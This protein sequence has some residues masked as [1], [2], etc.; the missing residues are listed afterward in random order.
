MEEKSI[1]IIGAGIA[2]LSTGC[3]GQMNGYHTQI[4][5]MRDLPGGLCTSW[6]R[7][8][9][10]IDGC[11]GWLM[12]SGPGYNYYQLWQELGALHGKRIINHE[13]F[14][15]IVDN[16][17][18]AL[19]IY[20][21][22]D[23][24]EGHLKEL[25]PEDA[26]EI[27]KLIQ[28]AKTCSTFNPP[29]KKAPELM[30]LADLIPFLFKNKQFLKINS[31]YRNITL[32]DYVKKFKSPFLRKMF[33]FLLVDLFSLIMMLG[34]LHKKSAG[35]P[36]GGSLEFSRGIEQRYLNLGGKIHYSSPVTEIIVENNRATGVKLLD[37]SIHHS[38]II[39]SAA[40]GHATI[41]DMLGGKYINKK[42]Q[43]YYNHFP[44]FPSKILLSSGVNRTFDDSPHWII[45][46]LDTPIVIG[47]QEY[48]SLGVEIYN[49]DHTLAPHGKTVLRMMFDTDYTYWYDLK[50]D[51][52]RY[53]ME[54]KKIAETV[55]SILDKCYPG[56][57]ALVE[58]I[59][60]AT[61]ITW[62]RYTGNWKGSYQG[63]Q[64]TEKTMPPFR[65]S[66]KLPG[67]ESFYMAGQ[68]VEPGGGLPPSALSGRNVIQLIC[69]Q[70]KKHFKTSFPY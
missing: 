66:K 18:K 17:G 55:I 52:D 4:F 15:R 69:K 54:K 63:W 11:I 21:D 30:G 65:M 24:L 56:L 9:Y 47:G 59:D 57:A 45:F 61:P 58:M 13:E 7:K 44:V 8:G 16:E 46:L 2:G 34:M 70:D 49:F 29:I 10:T 33:P 41:F 32:Q 23:K 12:G 62:E 68:W 6:K 40:D 43:Y 67:L 53:Q 42:I 60:V 31:K 26:D 28:L 50:Q 25:A 1:I 39:I 19:I 48:T 22:L 36:E 64:L 20:S 38:D 3:Y 37:G 14:L 35:Y 27:S 5:E 51:L